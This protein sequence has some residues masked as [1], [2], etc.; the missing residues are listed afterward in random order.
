MHITLR[1]LEKSARRLNCV[2]HLKY[3]DEYSDTIKKAEE[4][5]DY[6]KS[7]RHHCIICGSPAQ[8]NPCEDCK[9]EFPLK[10]ES[11]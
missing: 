1:D 11:N 2:Y 10:K 5:L 8:N 6:E 9:K 7:F 3:L 4:V